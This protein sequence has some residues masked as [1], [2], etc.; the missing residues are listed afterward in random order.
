MDEASAEH[1]NAQTLAFL[2]TVVPGSFQTTSVTF[3]FQG[4]ADGGDGVPRCFQ[5]P[6][7]GAGSSKVEAFHERPAC[8]RPMGAA[9]GGTQR[10]S[11]QGLG[12]GI[13]AL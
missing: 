12:P 5:G 8:P 10:A 6:S 9:D 13:Q 3:V 1:R 4:R 11:Q 7:G 2:E